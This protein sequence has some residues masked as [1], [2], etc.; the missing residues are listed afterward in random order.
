M[1]KRKLFDRRNTTMTIGMLS[2]VLGAICLFGLT[3]SA[4]AQD[5]SSPHDELAKWVGHWKVRIE[6]KETQFDHAKMEDYDAKCSFFPDNTFLF[7]DYR[8]LQ[9]SADSGRVVDDVALLYYS[10]ID[11][12]FKYTNVAREGGPSENVF[13]VDGAVWTRPFEIQSRSH[14][15]L[16]AREIY[17]FVPPNKQ[18][19][20]LEVSTDKGA[21]WVVV[22]EAV[23]VREH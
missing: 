2:S 10:E 16:N 11:K 1:S 4:A 17:T 9:P 8:G 7:C 18:L 3:A 19:G 22:N 20:R 23:G 15:T 6:T 13:Q 21:H 5:P 12:T 14:G